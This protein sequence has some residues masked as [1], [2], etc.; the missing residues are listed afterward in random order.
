[1][2]TA[3]RAQI[4]ITMSH[5]YSPLSAIELRGPQ[6]RRPAKI[7]VA[8]NGARRNKSDHPHLPMTIPEIVETADACYRAGADEIHLHV[9]D[10]NGAHSIDAGLYAEA[11][12]A[13]SEAAPLMTVQ[14]TTE[15]AGIFD[16]KTQ[17]ATLRALNPAAAS[18]S[19]REINRDR[20]R[21][22]SVYAQAQQSGTQ[23]QHI[24][25]DHDDLKRLRRWLDN[26][27]VPEHMRD[28]LMVFGAYHPPRHAQPQELSGFLTALGRDFPDWTIC[29]FGPHELD[30]AEVALWAG[31]NVRIGFENNLFGPDGKHAAS[32]AANIAH[33]VSLAHQIGRPLLREVPTP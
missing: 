9:R 11:I 28:V 25:Y 23:V 29:A 26:G 33:V 5:Y 4:G 15:S 32:N 19:I 13:V 20:K 3:T 18:I 12:A 2:Q 7:T 17:L 8:P 31:G 1:M 10:E 21:A 16:V 6:D 24:L 22:A 27:T 14:I 30:V